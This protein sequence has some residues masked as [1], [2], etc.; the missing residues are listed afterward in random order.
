MLHYLIVLPCQDSEKN[1]VLIKIGITFASDAIGTPV[2]RNKACF[3]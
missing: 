1:M 3:P 2:I